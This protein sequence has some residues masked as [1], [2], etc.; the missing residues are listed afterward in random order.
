ME[1]MKKILGKVTPTA[2]AITAALVVGGGSG[3]VAA[4]GMIHTR[5][6]ADNAVTTSK[7]DQGAVHQAD[8]ADGAK[9]ALRG[10]QGPAGKDG[11]DGVANVSANA[12]YTNTWK[13]DGGDQLNT[14]VEK[15]G[16]GQVALGGGYSTNNGDRDLGGDNKN[17]QITV[18]AP[19]TDNYVPVNDNGDLRP[20]EWIIKGY[21]N[22]DSDQIVRAWVVC[23]DAAP[24]G[25]QPQ[26]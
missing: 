21:N 15:C 24:S 8:I 5:D 12:V 4:T 23:A 9:D 20:D 1:Q 13:G 11:K 25:A 14:I 2:A 7:I 6:I 16:D 3:A 10:Q 22:G 17:I 26:S 18:S 19:Y